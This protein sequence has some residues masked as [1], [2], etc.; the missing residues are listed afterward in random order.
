MHTKVLSYN[1]LS[2][3]LSRLKNDRV[4]I[5]DIKSI[6]EDEHKIVLKRYRKYVAFLVFKWFKN[7]DIECKLHQFSSDWKDDSGTIIEFKRKVKLKF[8]WY[9]ELTHMNLSVDKRW[10]HNLPPK[11]LDLKYEWLLNLVLLAIN[12]YEENHLENINVNN[13]GV[14]ANYEATSKK[15][16]V[17][18]SKDNK[19]TVSETVVMTG[20]LEDPTSKVFQSN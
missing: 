2:K 12:A 6:T 11:F 9:D 10:G 17:K 4:D 15:I 5:D 13:D 20:N 1:H 7:N 8:P 14:F 18:I 19:W 3:K 16:E